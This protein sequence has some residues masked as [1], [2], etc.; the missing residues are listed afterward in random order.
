VANE[1]SRLPTHLAVALCLILPFPAVAQEGCA[2]VRQVLASAAQGFAALKDA[3]TKFS[4]RDV[5]RSRV[6]LPH[7]GACI[8]DPAGGFHG[9]PASFDCFSANVAALD[10]S[11]AAC[12]PG[13]RKTATADDPNGDNISFDLAGV[14]LMLDQAG[15]TLRIQLR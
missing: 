8:V 7:T 11:L 5:W 12:F 15:R 13:T 1:T 2:P 3:P 14:S 9:S 4:G 6:T 10:S